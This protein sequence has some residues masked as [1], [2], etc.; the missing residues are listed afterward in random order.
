MERRRRQTPYP[1]VPDILRQL[2]DAGIRLALVTD[3]APDLQ[4]EKAE[5]AG[6]TACFGAI[7]VSGEVGAG[8]PEAPLFMAALE[9]VG[10]RPEQAIMVGDNP[11][12]DIAGARACGIR[13]VL[14]ERGGAPGELVA[15]A[16]GPPVADARVS[17]L[18]QLL[19]L[20]VLP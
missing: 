19:P 1:E 2:V 5:L 17:D 7:V 14:V 9:R 18:R 16:G 11:H 8:K 10:A 12:R 20:L 3:G 15:D 4:R 13:G 6:L